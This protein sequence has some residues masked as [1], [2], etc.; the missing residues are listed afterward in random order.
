MTKGL[1]RQIV[2]NNC[3]RF[4]EAAVGILFEYKTMIVDDVYAYNGV[5]TKIFFTTQQKNILVR[6]EI[7]CFLGGF[8]P[9]NKIKICLIYSMCIN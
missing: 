1:V 7:F 5:S 2:L 6:K 8:T 4:L 9:T 3:R